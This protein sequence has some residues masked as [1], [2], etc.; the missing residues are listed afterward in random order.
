MCVLYSVHVCVKTQRSVIHVKRTFSACHLVIYSRQSRRPE[1]CVT[2]PGA[3]AVVVT[4]FLSHT[5][6]HVTT[7]IYTDG[8]REFLFYFSF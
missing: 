6:I 8:R 5:H 3:L 7:S 1:K 2:E 4:I